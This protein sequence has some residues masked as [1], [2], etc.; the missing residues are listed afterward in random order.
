[1]GKSNTA[2]LLRNRD[3]RL[4]L[5]WAN[6]PRTSF[7]YSPETLVWSEAEYAIPAMNQAEAD[8]LLEALKQETAS[9]LPHVEVVGPIEVPQPG[10][11]DLS[12]I[13]PHI[14]DI[15]DDI[16]KPFEHRIEEILR[17]GTDMGISG[18]R[19]DLM[20]MLMNAG[21][22]A[23]QDPTYY[24]SHDQLPDA[25]EEGNEVAFIAAVLEAGIE[26]VEAR[27]AIEEARQSGHKLH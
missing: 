1:M 26:V 15:L 25:E 20:A 17:R 10:I 2:W 16:G 18:T 5:A 13:T 4:Y 21:S 9:G 22:E 6:W 24:N 11:T 7:P 14:S 19:T 3:T 12:A 8:S 27:F 23:I